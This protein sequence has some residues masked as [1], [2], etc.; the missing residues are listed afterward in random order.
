M[1][2]GVKTDEDNTKLS[3]KNLNKGKII[4]QLQS[5]IDFQAIGKKHEQSINI[6]HHK[7][8]SISTLE[9]RFVDI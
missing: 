3:A 6:E 5:F 1:G 7:M 8:N 2:Y 9:E 4:I